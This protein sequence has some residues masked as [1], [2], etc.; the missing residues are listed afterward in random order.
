M[1]NEKYNFEKIKNELEI[2]E[3]NY[4]REKAQ[5]FESMG[6]TEEEVRTFLKKK[7]ATFTDAEKQF[8][9]MLLSSIDHDIQKRLDQY[10]PPE[11]VETNREAL[12]LPPSAIFCR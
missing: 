11:K 1:L 7:K 12:N 10:S 9:E 8:V 5:L 3:E 4:Q 6:M 2:F